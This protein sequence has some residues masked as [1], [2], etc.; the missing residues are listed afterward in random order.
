MGHDMSGWDPFGIEKIHQEVSQAI[1]DKKDG[2][3]QS[4][5][6]GATVSLYFDDCQT[7]LYHQPLDGMRHRDIV[8]EIII[9]VASK[10][11]LASDKTVRHSFVNW[12]IDD[13]RAYPKRFA[14]QHAEADRLETLVKDRPDLFV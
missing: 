10:E 4:D 8:Q 3:A 2:Y 13:R 5:V 7:R 11:G 14:K 12:M 6:S 1:N 9:D